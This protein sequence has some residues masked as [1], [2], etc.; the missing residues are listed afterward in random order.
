M[1]AAQRVNRMNAKVYLIILFEPSSP[2]MVTLWRMR[3][4]IPRAEVIM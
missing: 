1:N 3:M 4:K 2:P